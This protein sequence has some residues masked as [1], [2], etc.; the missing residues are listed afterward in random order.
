MRVRHKFVRFVSSVALLAAC[1]TAGAQSTSA[2]PSAPLPAPQSSPHAI[3]LTTRA[4]H[5]LPPEARR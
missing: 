2:P 3:I 5:S 1:L 4:V